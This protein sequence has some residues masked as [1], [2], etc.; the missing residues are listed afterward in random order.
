[1]QHALLDILDSSGNAEL[2]RSIPENQWPAIDS[3]ALTR[4]SADIAFVAQPELP[5]FEGHFPQLPVLPGVVQTHWVCLLS[6]CVFKI[7]G[8]F[9]RI[10][11]LKFISPILP[12]Q[13]VQLT[14]QFIAEREQVTFVYQNHS[15]G[16]IHF[17]DASC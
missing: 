3:V 14:M 6:Q 12:G 13:S 10:T 16:T 1:M 11:R 17:H 4:S 9:E 2:F 15:S 5:W 8:E 7:S